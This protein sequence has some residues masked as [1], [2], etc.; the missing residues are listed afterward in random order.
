MVTFDECLEMGS[1]AFSSGDYRRTMA[2][3]KASFA[4]CTKIGKNAFYYCSNLTDLYLTGMTAGSIVD[5]KTKSADED[6]GINNW[7]LNTSAVV[8]CMGGGTVYYDTNLGWKEL[9]T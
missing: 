7:A 3:T 5:N 6:S 8:H 4:K 9:G 2:I 1:N